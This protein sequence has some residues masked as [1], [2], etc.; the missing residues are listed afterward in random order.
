ML[1]DDGLIEVAFASETPVQRYGYTEVLRCNPQSVNGERLLA[2][3]PVL[4]NHDTGLQPGVVRSYRVDPD[5]VCRAR[6]A[7]SKSTL[8]Q[9]VRQDMIDGI[10][11]NISVGYSIDEI[12]EETRAGVDVVTATSWTPLE[13]SIVAV[14][15]DITVGVGRSL[16]PVDTPAISMSETT[17][18]PPIVQAARQKPDPS[19]IYQIADMQIFR[20]VEE[21]P[22]LARKAVETGMSE[23]AFRKQLT[24]VL[25]V[26]R[27]DKVRTAHVE[28]AEHVDGISL[29]RS[30]QALMRREVTDEIVASRELAKRSGVNLQSGDSVYLPFKRATATPLQATSFA[31]G[32][33]LVPQQYLPAEFIEYFRNMSVTAGLPIRMLSGLSGSVTIPEQ[34]GISAVSW[35]GENV[36][37]TETEPSFGAKTMAPKQMTVNSLVSRQLLM[38]GT[39]DAEVV[40]RA[41]QNAVMLLAMDLAILA[42]TGGNQPTGIWNTTGVQTVTFSTTATYA[43]LLEFET[44]LATSNVP[45][46]NIAWAVPPSVRQKW[47]SLS[48]ATATWS[49]FWDDSQQV[50]GYAT[51]TSNQISLANGM[52]AGGVL[53]GNWAEI[54]C[55]LWG[56]GIEVFL[57]PYSLQDKQQIRLTSVAY[58]DCV[59]RHPVAFV[60]STDSG[61]Q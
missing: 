14:P 39:P 61:A 59:L 5:G 41:D 21:L 35:G 25:E 13:I 7:F 38:Q 56:N 30:L 48:K 22:M 57:D 23:N 58:M 43:K 16:P 49:P 31:A 15:A 4:L 44:D 2:G 26:L 50:L 6:I 36:A 17:T 52:I 45:L 27:C 37:P 42:G 10:R 46:E 19:K 12:S 3:A 8:G 40:T 24:Q 33:A 18:A 20:E 51:R 34:T 47:K 54:F 53:Y 11:Q 55:G 9:E 32:G 60:K 29:V 1:L 28:L